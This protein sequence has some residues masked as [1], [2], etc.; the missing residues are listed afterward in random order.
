[1]ITLW[2]QRGQ[3]E[4]MEQEKE[5][6]WCY[7]ISHILMGKNEISKIGISWSIRTRT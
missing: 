3:E 2:H 5:E 7:M 4:E 6:R 1:M